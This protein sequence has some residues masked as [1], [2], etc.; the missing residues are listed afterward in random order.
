M[1]SPQAQAYLASPAVVAASALSGRISG[2]T[3]LDPASLPAPGSLQFEVMKTGSGTASAETASSATPA[4]SASAGEDILPTFPHSF[5]GPLIF[6]PQDNLT[7]DGIY[8]GKYTYQDDITPEGQ[9]DV[10]MENYD[11]KFSEI[12]ARLRAKLNIPAGKEGASA[13]SAV[14]DPDK[15]GELAKFGIILVGGF[16]FGTGSSREQAATAL[17]YAGVPLVIA[18]SFGDI[19]KR[20]AINNGLVCLESPALVEQ[21][22][23]RYAKDGQRGHGGKK[24]GEISVVFDGEGMEAVVNSRNG[25]VEVR[26]PDTARYEAT[27]RGI[28]RS[29]QEVYVA[30]GME[31]WV[32][33]RL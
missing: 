24:E 27:P 28:G 15:P 11:P 14:E 20:N 30:G 13:A 1:G 4:A 12:V 22:T 9:A 31:N 7:T 32:K 17:K 5:R 6:A 23:R 18:G 3:E 29:I 21:L 8:P 26:L 19:F 2:P 16:N 10:V 25:V 33:N